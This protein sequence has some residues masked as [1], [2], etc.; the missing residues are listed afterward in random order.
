MKNKSIL[1]IKGSFYFQ[2]KNLRVKRVFFIY[3]SGIFV[4]AFSIDNIC[5][6]VEYDK[7]MLKC[8]LCLLSN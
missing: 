1:D 2:M 8:K 4:W 6:K 7:K 3:K 5:D